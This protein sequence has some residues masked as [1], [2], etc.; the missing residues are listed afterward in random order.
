MDAIP[1]L[2]DLLA[3]I[4]GAS[5]R[6]YVKA[7]DGRK[8]ILSSPHCA[9]NYLLQGSAAVVA[10]R[11]LVLAHDNPYCCSQLAFIHDELQYECSPEHS[12]LLKSHLEATAA[13]AGT[14]YN[15]RI[16]I[17]AEGVIGTSWGDTH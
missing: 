5:D 4:K 10:K 2:A 8:V 15:L 13:E 11:W 1:G 3:A 12:S 14:Y 9:L 6:G 7:I 17:A 16:P